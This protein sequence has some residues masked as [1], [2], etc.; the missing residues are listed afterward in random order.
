MAPQILEGTWEDI[1]RHA[2]ELVGR[3]VR[4]TIL[5]EQDQPVPNERALAA[6]REIA[7]RQ[8]G[9]RHTSGENTQAML[10]QARAGGMYGLEPTED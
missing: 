8:K 1:L 4:L 10:R 9:Q 2:D 7:E 5:P 3:Q 6:L